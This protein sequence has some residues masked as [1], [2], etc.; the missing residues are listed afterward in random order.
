[1]NKL[2][3]TWNIQPKI[4]QQFEHLRILQGNN[5]STSAHNNWLDLVQPMIDIVKILTKKVSL[6]ANDYQ[7]IGDLIREIRTIS[8]SFTHQ[9]KIHNLTSEAEALLA[10]L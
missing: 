10:T 4:Q 1:M 7:H 5:V 9:D 3:Q 2:Y 8:H 6:S